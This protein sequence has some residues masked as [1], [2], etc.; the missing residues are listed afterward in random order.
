MP[1]QD[2]RM[3]PLYPTKYSYPLARPLLY[4]F[5]LDECLKW[6][7]VPKIAR[8]SNSK[9]ATGW[10]PIGIGLGSTTPSAV[11]AAG[12][13]LR[14]PWSFP[15]S[16]PL[17]SGDGCPGLVGGRKM[18]D[19]QRIDAAQ[20]DGTT[21]LLW[22][23]RSES[24]ESIGQSR[25]FLGRFDGSNWVSDGGDTIWPTHWMPLPPAPRN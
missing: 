19:W 11:Q 22:A 24:S 3:E 5:I 25:C 12:R 8:S 16:V 17:S 6:R 21:M 9:S 1:G 4:V 10:N 7:N 23:M 14:R 13:Q 2:L 15:H 20:T 18:S